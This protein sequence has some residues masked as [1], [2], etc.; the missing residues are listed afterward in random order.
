MAYYPFTE[1]VWKTLAM[2]AV[3]CIARGVEGTAAAPGNPRVDALRQR[4][5]GILR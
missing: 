2:A 3:E 4:G 1:S 5:I